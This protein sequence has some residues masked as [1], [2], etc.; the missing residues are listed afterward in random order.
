MQNLNLAIQRSG[1][2]ISLQI[3]KRASGGG[4]LNYNLLHNKPSIN[5]VELINDKSFEELGEENLTNI[6]I[7]SIFDRIFG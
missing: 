3:D 5:G 4:T 6:E 2:D 1:G 7:K